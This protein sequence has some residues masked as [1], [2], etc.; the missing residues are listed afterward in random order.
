M[1]TRRQ[2]QQQRLSAPPIVRS[3]SIS[4][5]PSNYVLK[6]DTI[7]TVSTLQFGARRLLEIQALHQRTKKDNHTHCI[8]NI[9]NCNPKSAV[10][11]SVSLLQHSLQSGGKKRSSRHLRRRATSYQPKRRRRGTLL[12]RQ[13]TAI[14]STASVVDL[15]PPSLLEPQ[16]PPYLPSRRIR[17]QCNIS[18]KNKDNNTHLTW[19]TCYNRSSAASSNISSLAFGSPSLSS[20]ATTA[21]L[22]TSS[23]NSS[24]RS[25]STT[26][27]M[28]THIWCRKRFHMLRGWNWYLPML[29]TNRGGAAAVRL[30][31]QQPSNHR[32]TTSTNIISEVHTTRSKCLIYDATWS[33]QPIWFRI[34]QPS[35]SSSSSSS[36]E[37]EATAP[38]PDAV[39]EHKLLLP[40]LLQSILP[41]FDM[42][43]HLKT[44]HMISHDGIIYDLPSPPPSQDNKNDN[45]SPHQPQRQQPKRA[46]GPVTWIYTPDVSLLDHDRDS[47]DSEN[48]GDAHHYLYLIAHPSIQPR[49]RTLLD[50]FLQ[51]SGSSS[52]STTT[53]KTATEGMR[54][55]G[56]YMGIQN[57]LTCLKLRGSNVSIV[58]CL[59]NTWFDFLRGH[60]DQK[61]NRD[62]YDD[63]N[64]NHDVGSPLSSSLVAMD[65]CIPACTVDINNNNGDD[66]KL[67]DFIQN[68]DT[69][70]N[71]TVMTFRCSK[72]CILTR[73]QQ[74]NSNGGGGGG[75]AEDGCTAAAPN[76][77]D[78]GNTSSMS[79]T[80][81]RICTV[82]QELGSLWL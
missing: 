18:N 4:T 17:R 16:P 3:S 2:Q 42:D 46:I 29:H 51:R 48:K 59:C 13:H 77:N 30:V 70:P 45:G 58:H 44:K 65:R 66:D 74:R 75:G 25:H 6:D 63:N 80:I 57:G 8:S 24:H 60:K 11:S 49:I 78:T 50:T 54:C 14:A 36:F 7:G 79:I 37:A 71:N 34:R 22:A 20:S 73:Q 72:N 39:S 31:Q 1:V 33:V 5:I 55:D 28:M 67:Y 82:V 26:H 15:Q 76:Q 69:I 40:L 12:L 56:P 27:W 21:A 32:H 35:S 10:A 9:P 81:R 38:S 53:T 64:S 19:R 62:D 47:S 23:S 43:Q 52:S 41:D 68:I 61:K